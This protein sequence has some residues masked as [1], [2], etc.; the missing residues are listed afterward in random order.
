[1]NEY[2]NKIQILLEKEERPICFTDISHC[3]ECAEHNDTLNK[4][5]RDELYPELFNYPGNDPIECTTDS[6]YR[7]LFPKLCELAYGTG[8]LYHFDPFIFHLP[9]RLLAFSN[10]ERN[11]IKLLLDDLGKALNADLDFINHGDEDL[12]IVRTAI[13]EMEGWPARI[14]G[15]K[16]IRIAYGS[17]EV[18]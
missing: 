13:K 7:Y 17:D 5:K 15:P 9:R 8:E 16:E 2:L 12:N 10:T 6:A 11:S 14:R 4:Y 18:L 1:M 3:H